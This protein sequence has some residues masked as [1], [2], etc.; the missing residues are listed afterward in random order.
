VNWRLG[1]ERGY[2]LVA[3]RAFPKADV[4]LRRPSLINGAMATHN[5]ITVR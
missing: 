5:L 1:N 4:G 3:A 2:R